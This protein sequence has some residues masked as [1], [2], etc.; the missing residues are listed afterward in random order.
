MEYSLTIEEIDILIDHYE[1]QLSEA[2]FD[3]DHGHSFICF[4]RASGQQIH[5]PEYT[6]CEMLELQQEI[7]ELEYLRKLTEYSLENDC[8][9]II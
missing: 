2:K 6:D 7:N 9:I 1:E 5:V 3:N 8:T 4:D